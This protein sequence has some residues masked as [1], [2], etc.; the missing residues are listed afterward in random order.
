[1]LPWVEQHLVQKFA[2]HGQGI[3]YRVSTSG[4]GAGVLS[5]LHAFR[6]ALLLLLL[7]REREREKEREKERERERDPFARYNTSCSTPR[8]AATTF[9]VCMRVLV[10]STSASGLARAQ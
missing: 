7:P 1:M 4:I 10:Q 6:V 8:S 2:A 5:Q 9:V 3:G